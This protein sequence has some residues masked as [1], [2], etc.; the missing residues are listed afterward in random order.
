MHFATASVLAKVAQMDCFGE[1]S[2]KYSCLVREPEAFHGTTLKL[3][4]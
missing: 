4:S 3:D 1:A 2:G